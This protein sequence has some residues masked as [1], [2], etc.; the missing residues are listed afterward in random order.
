[1]C[2]ESTHTVVPRIRCI[3]V[4]MAPPCECFWKIGVF[5]IFLQMLPQ[6]K[7]YFQKPKCEHH[8]RSRR[9]LCA[10]FDIRRPSQS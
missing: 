5:G 8:P 9:H 1:M 10:K 6:L 4:F 3:C 7:N 2:G